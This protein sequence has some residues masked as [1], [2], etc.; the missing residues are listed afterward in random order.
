M[1]II[2]TPLVIS[3][4]M[5]TLCFKL[6]DWQQ[7]S[8]GAGLVNE[9]FTR[10]QDFGKAL[11]S[12]MQNMKKAV[13]LELPDEK[14][15]QVELKQKVFE[16]TAMNQ[17]LVEI[18]VQTLNTWCRQMEDLL[19]DNVA[20]SNQKS[21]SRGADEGP[22]AEL[23]FWR[24]RSYKFSTIIDQL[25]CDGCKMILGVLK[26]AKAL[27]DAAHRCF[28]SWRSLD[29]KITD[30]G[31]EAKDNVKFLSTLDK[32]VD[33]LYNGSIEDVE[34]ILPPLMT[35]VKMMQKISRFYNSSE[36]MTTL[37]WRITNQIIVNCKKQIMTGGRLW[38]QDPDTVCE[39]MRSAQRL[40]INYLTAYED[41]KNRTVLVKAPEGTDDF[42]F[43]EEKIF[44]H[45]EMFVKRLDKVI[46]MFS[47][48][49]QYRFMAQRAVEGMEVHIQA[50]E[51]VIEEA[52]RKPYDILDH[53]KTSF[54][55][56]Y[57]DFCSKINKVEADLQA[58]IN[59]SFE[60]IPNT[61]MA[62]ELLHK[63]YGTIR[64]KR[65][66][67]DLEIKHMVIFQNYGLD[68]D[69]VQKTY[70][71]FKTTPPMVRTIPPVSGSIIW[72]RQLLRRI[73]APMDQFQTNEATM[74]MKE[75]KKIIRT[76]NKVAKA[77]I[78]F[79]TMWQEAWCE[80]IE[81]SK[82]GLHATL[83]IKH[84]HNPRIFANF[85]PEI[86]QL[87]REAKCL[88]HLGIDVPENARIVLMQ[89]VKFKNLF[90]Q[91]LSTL[92]EH[93]HVVGRVNP[94]IK[95]LMQYHLDELQ[96]KVN[97]G[98]TTITWTSLNIE[99]YFETVDAALFK[100]D[101][102]VSKMNDII[103]NRIEKNL[104][105]IS[106]TSL[107]DLAPEK[108]PFLVDDFV[109]IQEQYVKDQSSY[110]DAKNLEV[111]LAVQDLIDLVNNATAAEGKPNIALEENPNAVPILVRHYNRL[112]YHAILAAMKLSFNQIKSRIVKE[113]MSISD[114]TLRKAPKE[115]PA[116]FIAD[117]EVDHNQAHANAEKRAVVMK[118]SL[119][120]IQDTINRTAI[121]VLRSA[122][123]VI[124]WGQDRSQQSLDRETGATDTDPLMSFYDELA[125]EKEVCKL[126]ILLT[127]SLLG[128]EIT[129]NEYLE[130]FDHYR[131]LWEKNMQKE[132]NDFLGTDPTLEDFDD[133]L[134]KY[135]TY[136]TE[137]QAFPQYN[138]IGVLSLRSDNIKRDLTSF[139]NLWKT[140]YT[141][142][143]L[144]MARDDLEALV[145][146][147]AGTMRK[148]N[149]NAE[150]LDDVRK[151]VGLLQEVREKESIVEWEFGP[152]EEKYV[153]LERYGV[154]SL[155][156]EELH[157]VAEIRVSWKKLKELTVG[158][159]DDLLE[160]QK[161]HKKALIKQVK[162]FKKQVKVYRD[163]YNKNGP[164]IK[165]I[166]P[167]KA[168]ERLNKHEGI[169]GDMERKY[170]MYNAGEVLFGMPATNLEEMTKT[171]KELKLLRQLYG[172][173]ENVENTV[174]GYNEILWT[175]VLAN[176]DTMTNQVND[177]QKMCKNMPKAL[178][179]W[180]AYNELKKSID[181][182]LETVP[183]LQFLSNKAMRDRH[184]DQ[185]NE[186]TGVKFNMDP[187]TFKIGDILAA[188]LLQVAEDIEEI[189]MGSTK[190]L[191]VELKLREIEEQWADKVF[192]FGGYK[193][194]SG[195]YILK[196]VETQETQELL[197]ESLMN[198]G[199]M[200]S[201]RY[202]LPFKESVDE[203]LAKLGETME[204]TERWLYLQMLWMNLEAVFTGG[205]IAKQLPQDSK[206]FVSID[207]TW[208]K[209]MAKAYDQRNVIGLCYANDML[210]FLQPLIEGLETCQRSL[211][212]YLESKRA[213]FPRFY[214]VSDPVLLEILSQGS[215]PPAIQPY[216]QACFDSIDWVDFDE[217]DKK[218]IIAINAQ[219]G[220]DKETVEFS[221]VVNADG[222][223]EEWLAKIE[224]E[225]QRSIHDIVRQ[226]AVD[227]LSQDIGTF[228]QG[229]NAQTCILGIQMQW[230]QESQTAIASSKQDKQIMGVTA[231]RFTALM[232]TLCDMTTDD[233]LGKRDR[234][235]VETL[236][237]IE[238]HQKD[239]FDD[240]LKKKLKDA[241]SFDWMQQL[242]FYYR[243][244]LDACLA[245]CCDRPF[246]YSNE[247]LGCEERLVITPLTDRCYV[248]LTQALGMI[249]GGAPAG[250]AGTGKTE[251]TKDLARALAKYCVVTNCGPEMDIRA[252][253][254]IFKGIAMAGAWGC[255]DEFNRIELEVL[256]VCA[257]QI[258]CVL[259]AIRDKAKEFQ[260][261]DGQILT[262]NP[263]CG[264]FI[265]MNP[266]YAGRQELPENLKD[267]F[268]GVTMMVPDRQIIMKVKL[269]A[270]GFQEYQP[271]SVKFHVLYRLCEQ[272]LSKQ[273][274]YDFGLRNILSVLRTAGTQLR[275]EKK[276]AEATGG[277]M[278]SELYLL[279][280]TL[281]DMN[282]SKFVA[283]DVSLFISLINDLFPGLN[284]EK[285]VFP[286]EEK[287][288]HDCCIEANLQLHPTWVGKIVQLYETYLVRHGIMVVGTA[289]CG[290]SKIILMLK[291]A[292]SRV[293]NKHTIIKMNPK[294]ITP[295]QMYGFQ[296]PVA[297][298]WTEG[299]FTM[300]WKKSND[301]RKKGVNQWMVMDGPVDAIWIEDL[302][303]VLDD[304]RM[305][306]CA[307]GDRIPMLSSMKIMFE[308]ENLNNASPATV[309]R[310]GIIFVSTND[311]GW[312]PIIASWL[313]NRPNKAE[314]ELLTGLMTKF[315]KHCITFCVEGGCRQVM[316]VEDMNLVS[317][318]IS[319]AESILPELKE[320]DTPLNPDAMS[321][322]LAFASLWSF[323]ALYETEARL[324]FEE[325]VRKLDS[326]CLPDCKEGQSCYDF[327][328]DP[329]KQFQ[330]TTWSVAPLRV[331]NP[332]K[333]DFA[334][335]L[336]P[337]MD[338]ARMQFLMSKMLGLKVPFMMVGGPGTAKTSI[339][340]MY[341]DA[342]PKSQV[343]HKRMNFSSATS[344]LIF[345]RI[346]ESTVEKRSGKIFGPP[347][348][349]KLL[350]FLDDVS[351]PEINKW[352]D[353]VTLEIIRQLVE[354]GYLWN[355]EKSKAG[356]QEFIEDLIYVLA[357]NHPG[358]GKNDIPQ[359]IKRHCANI[360][361]PMPA[362]SSINQIFG[363][364]LKLRFNSKDFKADVVNVA[365]SLTGVTM[366]LYQRTKAK[367]LPTPA[368]FHYIFN[369]RDVSRVFQ[370]IMTI[371]TAIQKKPTNCSLNPA[372]FLIAAWRHE[373]QRVYQDKLVDA[374]DKNWLDNTLL[375]LIEANYDEIIPIDIVRPNMYLVDFLRDSPEDPETGE[376]IG[377]RPRMYEPVKNLDQLKLRAE[378]LMNE[379]N[380]GLRVGKMFLVLFDDAL[381]HMIR[382]ARIIMMPRG[383]GLLVGVGGSGKQSLTRLATYILDYDR[384]H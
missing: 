150:T 359:R 190:E 25:K 277:K 329:Q 285:A 35:N 342:Q 95:G 290:K 225:M 202:A 219:V 19:K 241:G 256:S 39:K 100:M 173:Y 300:L 103:E 254:K 258:A 118:P 168:L 328:L 339:A 40:Y 23:L 237:T 43:D 7:D 374:N 216:F 306:T 69:F 58:F 59:E 132:Y 164:G 240:L 93:E 322:V 259:N 24:D 107:V 325:N 141:K 30:A 353:Q 330:W 297:N 122:K 191:N 284:P 366:E 360:N 172:L 205:D 38:D 18:Y 288:I 179:E 317:T 269:A 304:N 155:N 13:R 105:E 156:Q 194:R 21:K 250:P 3:R 184:W 182:L 96:V 313:Q 45:M 51:G 226:A 4:T 247:F 15:L 142:N 72:S 187:D 123:R 16:K 174:Q 55:R 62:L 310:A 268:R 79:E 106:K 175:E 255:F 176:I 338:A 367:L 90:G 197:E 146:Y 356:E 211:A 249:K 5:L 229:Y 362:L 296:D 246:Y 31:N 188:N 333:F 203:W 75:G 221:Q 133:E 371:P 32:Y 252:T 148:F 215:D 302:N 283:D 144:E 47:T 137:V 78:Q 351:M 186:V 97:P 196:G 239:V 29:N 115:L 66:Q 14:W 273:P 170:T 354:L 289:G 230:T 352:G 301:P 171:R 232:A 294:G 134:T 217:K 116:F 27:D 381:K 380:E 195:V 346:I 124:Q 159:T 233:N 372:Q 378:S 109:T 358:G 91:I 227:C 98:L 140:Q 345:Q 355:L 320:K 70:E 292:L 63:F 83:M 42:E 192:F 101:D 119:P 68:L 253:G 89:D 87:I 332:D 244:D 350:V 61:E 33:V 165:G 86:L 373:C 257:Q 177:F 110:M 364:I 311:L 376:P 242:R 64:R 291:E 336:V 44:G 243:T 65:L 149:V 162:D 262:V 8:N 104:K 166:S 82:A 207:K 379:M 368:K 28:T 60:V 208:V 384:F 375:H 189:S 222:N 261:L 160:H 139:T 48:I 131:F 281:R 303:T 204:V 344:P 138:N 41:V 81:M 319:C 117:I 1:S 50:F 238:V 210:K 251:T 278:K 347:A 231:K 99:Q 224:Q 102:V 271:L 363:A 315:A 84:P 276:I 178:K 193:N 153:M 111:E 80:S 112:M 10:A 167:K 357:M 147:M 135:V 298:E 212:S 282:M 270:A 158:V 183:L 180:D 2:I 274:H 321:R 57:L 220:S 130:Q 6:Q 293:F 92:K 228:I 152:L 126:V 169:F 236:I 235:N 365:Q 349:K 52:Q 312:Q 287:A 200:A 326:K 11:D 127:G 157:Q 206:R 323:G 308:P 341:I 272:Q 198:L 295:K 151:L 234:R 129:V 286:D 245:E 260:F 214:F 17:D 213:L 125:R 223:I 113:K 136:E 218:K 74:A 73:A 201:S 76:Y 46:D 324:K 22:R 26:E 77:L 163:D 67:D 265:T 199:G 279:C 145:E 316:S 85:D 318:F 264:Y 37:C 34:D 263:V 305:L 309:S 53:T 181:D 128:A 280:R 377:P 337:T 20:N 340:M 71:K 36:R 331:E 88:V 209:L 49:S 266:G 334:S 154:K 185:V 275:N 369:L 335:L 299:I 327:S 56:D 307:N 361:V 94:V 143:L 383:S 248:T 382:I 114:L 120:D 9:L 314:R 343:L 161:K 348:N 370:G 12:A 108:F 121:Q 54:E 267:L